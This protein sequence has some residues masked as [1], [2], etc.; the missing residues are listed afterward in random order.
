[1]DTNEVSKM[2]AYQ[3]LFTLK[4]PGPSYCDPYMFSSKN[5]IM[6]IRIQN[7]KSNRIKQNGKT[8]FMDKLMLYTHNVES[9]S[10]LWT[11][12]TKFTWN[13]KS[14]IPKR[15]YYMILFV[16]SSGKVKTNL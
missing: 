3:L 7:E 8:N 4:W 16:W 1:M 5:E 6:I 15:K 10:A 14:H 12:L 2:T 11:N 13:S 9:N